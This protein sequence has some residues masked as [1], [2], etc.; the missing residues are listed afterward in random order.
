MEELTSGFDEARQAGGD[1]CLAT[2]YWEVDN[3]M[4]RVMVSV[5]DYAARH[6]DVRFVPAEELFA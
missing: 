2:H 1:F 3:S 6:S 5:L 4:K